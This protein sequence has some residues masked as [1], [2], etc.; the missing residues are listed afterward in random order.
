[1]SQPSPDAEPSAVAA[2]LLT[3]LQL[4]LRLAAGQA[5]EQI[6]ALFGIAVARLERRAGRVREEAL[7][8][9][10][11]RSLPLEWRFNRL[12][13]LA[14][15]RLHEA[16]AAGVKGAREFFR[17]SWSYNE[18]PAQRIAALAEAKLARVD[19]VSDKSAQPRAR[20]ATRRP[21]ASPRARLGHVALRFA[22][23]L[24]DQVIAEEG[25]ELRREQQLRPRD[26]QGRWPRDRRMHYV[27]MPPWWVTSLTVPPQPGKLW[28]ELELPEGIP[29]PPPQGIP[30]HGR[31][32]Y[33]PAWPGLPQPFAW[34]E[35]G[36]T[37]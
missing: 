14:H 24:R 6:A 36:S 7:G 21:T 2:L 13:K 10:A 31:H 34:V 30:P 11:L 1:M 9:R 25:K 12:T 37:S 3:R 4:V 29:R 16:M 15:T 26:R 18:D 27:P 8:I 20:L 17:W 5:V 23:S 19:L 32:I 22:L 35:K 28:A 33:V